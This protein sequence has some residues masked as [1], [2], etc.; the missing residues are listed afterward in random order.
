MMFN[1]QHP[2][3]SLAALIV[4][5]TTPI[6]SA[7]AFAWQPTPTEFALLPEHCKAKISDYLEHRNGKWRHS[8]PINEKKIQHYKNIIGSDFRHMHH[9]CAGL[10]Y[11]SQAK[12]SRNRSAWFF[13]QAEAEISYTIGKSR[14]T[15]PLWIEMNVAQA[16]ARA[17]LG[18]HNEALQQ[19]HDC[20]EL[21]PRSETLYIEIAKTLK[22]TGQINDA[23][24]TLEEGLRN[25]GKAGPLLYWLALYHYDLGDLTKARESM[26]RAEANGMK[27][28]RLRRKLG[29]E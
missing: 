18:K 2:L 1:I 25:G 21:E 10:A 7:Y 11:L 23:V 5:L 6:Q 12:T 8:F 4:L 28:S 29:P 26:E 27:M 22:Q 24:I 15:N 3:L 14:P 9:Y 17:G 13:R 20:L 16:K 19:L